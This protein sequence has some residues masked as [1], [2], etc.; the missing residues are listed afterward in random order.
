MIVER[1]SAVGGEDANRKNPKKGSP[2]TDKGILPRRSTLEK[3]R[4][5]GST[6]GEYAL[7]LRKDSLKTGKKLQRKK[8]Q[9][10]LK[11]AFPP[12]PEP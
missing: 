3:K 12:I 4:R 11:G 6:R 8:D 5:G 2:S 9:K 10:S 1:I 7:L